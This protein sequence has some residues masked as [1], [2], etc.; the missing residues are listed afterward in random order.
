MLCQKCDLHKKSKVN[1]LPGGGS[2]GGIMIVGESPTIEAESEGRVSAGRPYSVLRDVFNNVGLHTE[3]IYYT[4]IIKCRSRSLDGKSNKTPL[5]KEIGACGEYLEKEILEVNPYFV[6]CLGSTVAKRMGCKGSRG[7]IVKSVKYPFFCMYTHPPT[8]VLNK[9]AFYPIFYKDI[10]CITEFIKEYKKDTKITS[11][12]P[13]IKEIEYQIVDDKETLISAV[14]RLNEVEVFALDIETT[15]FNYR[16]DDIIC[17][18]FSWKKD[19]GITIP[20]IKKQEDKIIKIWENDEWL[21]EILKNKGLKIG[22]NLAFENRFFLYKGYE[23]NNFSFDTMVA[24]YCLS[25][26]GIHDLKTLAYLLTDK[27]NYEKELDLEKERV[28]IKGNKGS[29]IFKYFSYLDVNSN[30]LWK[31]NAYDAAVTLE[32]Y[33]I[34]KKK[35]EEENILNLFQ[36]ELIPLITLLVRS[37][38]RGMNIDLDHLKN[39]RIKHHQET[40][41]LLSQFLSDV[42]QVGVEE[43]NL[44]SPKQLC[45]LFFKVL[46]LRSV[47]QTKSGGDSLN[48]EALKLLAPHHFLAQKLL[49]Y[50][51]IQ[52]KEKFLKGMEEAL[53]EDNAVHCNFNITNEVTGRVATTEPNLQSTHG[54]PEVKNIFKAREKY[55]LVQGDYAQQEL[56]ILA[57]LTGDE[58]ML[59]SFRKGEDIHVRTACEI[60]GCNPE[61]VDKQKRSIAKSINF[62]LMYGR[63]AASVALQ[64]GCSKEEA[65]RFM[66]IF[67]ERCPRVKSWID[68]R[69]NEV[70]SRGYV[71]NMFGRRRRF[72]I[73]S[74]ASKKEF[75]ECLRQSQNFAIQSGGADVTFLSAL[76]VAD[77]FKIESID[78]HLLLV[79]HDALLYE[80]N[81][82]QEKR[83]LEII[84]EE[85]E[86]DVKGLNVHMSV[87]I[88]IGDKWGELHEIE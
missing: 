28:D 64:V 18:G 13:K 72:P 33:E 55:I 60:L 36:T 75:S 78:G 76:R 82:Q 56:R 44:N 25:E 71:T 74:I 27:G 35:L 31:Y 62:G 38:F 4:N 37:Q 63:S 87:D 14:N 32:L 26:E 40:E 53:A 7:E 79:I 67:F 43:L 1:C 12:T 83:G 29:F 85:M 77:R 48:E 20:I 45:N 54:D 50:R 21:R 70:K 59:E 41:Q 81:K 65:E 49:D 2:K 39:L 47:K 10:Q 86:R 15:G 46:G 16:K 5:V 88:K 17:I 57:A 68:A 19:T 6:L 52:G 73:V 66:K 80:L 42:K 3:Q 11:Y 34:F 58:K 51:E 22:H 61:E 30:I 84:K 69:H 24:H 8:S 9:Y 23:V